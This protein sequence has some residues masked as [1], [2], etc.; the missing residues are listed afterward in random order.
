MKPIVKVDRISSVEEAIQLQQLSV[1]VIGISLTPDYKFQDCR[2]LSLDTVDEIRS[3]LKDSR[4][5]CEL[6]SVNDSLDLINSHRFNL[7]QCSERTILNSK[8]K[9]IL[10]EAKIGLMVFVGYNF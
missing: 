2:Y 5:C 4:L 9:K 10:E 8:S 3:V 1:D 7:I 6:E